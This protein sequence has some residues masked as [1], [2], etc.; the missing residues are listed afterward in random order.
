MV[1]LSKTSK[2]RAQDVYQLLEAH[3]GKRTWEARRGPLEELV[4]TV[5]SQHN[6]DTN[7]FRTYAKLTERYSTWQAVMDADVEEIEETIRLGGLAKVKAPRIQAILHDIESKRGV[8][9]LAFLEAVPFEEARQWLL[10]LPGVGP[11]TA[12]CVLLFSFGLPALPV[13]TH[14][15]RVSKRLGLI[16]EKMSADKAHP[17]LEAL[18]ATE[19]V[20]QFHVDLIEHGRQTCHAQRPNCGA[21]VL[22]EICPSSLVGKVQTKAKAKR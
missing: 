19:Q 21:C 7:T 16:D 18:V 15:H 12:A 4:F 8:L 11:K 10:D 17:A 20:Y 22:N 13:D 5:L 9:D 2:K 3:Y 1:I 6:S 14:V